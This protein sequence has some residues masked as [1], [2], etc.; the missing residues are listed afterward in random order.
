[1]RTLKHWSIHY[2]AIIIQAFVKVFWS[3]N[4]YLLLAVWQGFEEPSIGIVCTFM[5]RASYYMGLE[6]K[7]KWDSIGITE[8]LLGLQCASQKKG[9]KLFGIL[10]GF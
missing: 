7:V 1:M 2:S 3:F 9:T 5:T 8:K 10:E 4:F 6:K